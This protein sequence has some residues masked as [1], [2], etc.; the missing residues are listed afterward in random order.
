MYTKLPYLTLK[1]FVPFKGTLR[2]T[3]QVS[4]STQGAVFD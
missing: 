4:A 2:S 3:L 1:G